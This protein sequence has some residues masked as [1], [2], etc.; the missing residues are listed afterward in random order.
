MD[1]HVCPCVNSLHV[2]CRSRISA[3]ENP[4]NSEQQVIELNI[5][6]TSRVTHSFE[7]RFEQ[8]LLDDRLI[9]EKIVRNYP[10]SG[11][12]QIYPI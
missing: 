2:E 8:T 4:G 10:L 7:L 12:T 3:Q 1:V 11:F 9:I 6:I 5:R